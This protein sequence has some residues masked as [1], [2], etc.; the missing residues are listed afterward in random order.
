VLGL[1]GKRVIDLAVL[2]L[3]LYAFAFV[4]IG[5]HTGLE[6]ARRILATPAAKSAGHDLLDAA[7]R[8]RARLLGGG[9]D[10]KIEPSGAK[11]LV[12]K[13]PKGKAPADMILA[14]RPEPPD[15]SL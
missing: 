12:P 6:H 14:A 4:P 9:G 7:D 11:P 5:R 3:A 2:F 8:L 15:A 10:E 13:M 1:F